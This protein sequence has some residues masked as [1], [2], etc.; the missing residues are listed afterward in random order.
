[1]IRGYYVWKEMSRDFKVHPFFCRSI[2][3]GSIQRAAFQ[4]IS[5]FM[6]GRFGSAN[7][8]EYRPQPCAKVFGTTLSG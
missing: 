4:Q 3:G 2:F 8:T 1:M 7:T 5:G 6:G